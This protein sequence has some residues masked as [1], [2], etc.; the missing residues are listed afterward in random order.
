[1]DL[2]KASLDLAQ[3]ALFHQSTLLFTSPP[4]FFSCLSFPLSS[5]MEPSPFNI[6]TGGV[7]MLM[8]LE[9]RTIDPSKTMEI[10]RIYVDFGIVRSQHRLQSHPKQ[11]KI[12]LHPMWVVDSTGSNSLIKIPLLASVCVWW[13]NGSHDQTIPINQRRMV[14]IRL[15][16]ELIHI[17]CRANSS[18]SFGIHH[19]R[20]I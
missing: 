10:T 8:M 17:F 2:C 13:P 15:F 12:V 4:P 19:M 6:W 9:N 1:M 14:E 18:N 3:C 11:Q 16:E 7:C 20:F 5:S